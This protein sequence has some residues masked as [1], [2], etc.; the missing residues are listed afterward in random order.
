MRPRRSADAAC[1][2]QEKR[3]VPCYVVPD[4]G[5][6][7]ILAD[8]LRR[9]KSGSASWPMPGSAWKVWSDGFRKEPKASGMSPS[10][11]ERGSPTAVRP[12][13]L[14]GQPLRSGRLRR[15]L[16]T[17]GEPEPDAPGA[18]DGPVPAPDGTTRVPAEDVPRA[19]AQHAG[20]AGLRASR[21]DL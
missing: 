8:L 16:V 12:G 6:G 13:R 19:A 21:I 5:R 18:V 2:R 3:E 15:P 10:N 7:A 11:P 4:P 14:Y 1:V 9:S 20:A 17:W